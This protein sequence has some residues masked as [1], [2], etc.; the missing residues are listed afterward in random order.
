MKKAEKKQLQKR[1]QILLK[2]LAA[3]IALV[4]IWGLAVEPLLLTV[5]EVEYRDSRLP[6]ELDGIRVVFISDVHVGPYY[7]EK[8]V[9]RLA[10]RIA[11]LEPDMVLFGGDLLWHEPDALLVDR[12][13]VS[14]AFA[15]LTPRLGKFA[16]YGNHDIISLQTKKIAEIILTDGGFTVLENSA[17]EVSPGFIVAGTASWPMEGEDSPR[18]HADV[19]KVAWIT[20]DNAFSLLLSH[21]PAQIRK[22]ADYPFALQLSGHTHGG[23]V[24]L[25]YVGPIILPG[26]TEVYKAGFYTLKET[27]MYVTRGIGTSVVRVR[28][29]APPEIVVLTLHKE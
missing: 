19:G 8:N 26:G 28:L 4:L 17:V 20:E 16:V 21:E 12:K 11:G 18:N 13:R 10:A 29:F 23:Q 1:A 15:A 6:K 25:P 22:N 14:A 9:E 5:S 7:T 27:R 3:A 2:V 24:A